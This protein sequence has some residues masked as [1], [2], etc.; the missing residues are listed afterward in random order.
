LTRYDEEYNEINRL[1][2]VYKVCFDR[3]D[4]IRIYVETAQDKFA[5]AVDERRARFNALFADIHTYRWLDFLGAGRMVVEFLL[6]F[7]AFVTTVLGIYIFFK[8][9]SRKV[10]G[11]AYVR[12]RRY[13]RYVAIVVSVF[14]LMFTFSGGYH[15]LSKLKDDTRDQ[16]FVWERTAARD[17]K[18]GLTDVFSGATGTSVPGVESKAGGC[19]TGLDLVR[20][21]GQ[22]YW[23][24]SMG[25]R[26]SGPTPLGKSIVSGDAPKDLMKSMSAI[27]TAL[28]Y[29]D[30]EY[31]SELVQG[32]RKYALYLAS[33]FSGHRPADTLSIR[34]ITK[35]D[36]EYN[37]TDKRLPVYRVAYRDNNRERYYVETSSGRLSVRVDNLDLTEAYVFAFM[38]K[39]EFLSW[40]GKSVK[41]ASTMF[42]A[43]TQVLMVLLGLILYLAYR[44]RQL[45]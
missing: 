12:K 38:H 21:N 3:A 40:A 44:K 32:D 6:V 11:N 16:Y 42:W 5:F 43:A 27:P 23:Q 34:Y 14:T 4:S 18:D 24:V 10:A 9:R 15:A 30:E 31:G 8:T 35:F 19:V 29:I 45:S 22:L 2:P 39:H 26:A 37:F 25:V 13:H 20:L 41:D 33:L 7:I 1:L 28:H 17:L 36:N